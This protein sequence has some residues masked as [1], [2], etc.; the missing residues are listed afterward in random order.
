MRAH[1]DP[2][3]L[4]LPAKKNISASQ[5]WHNHSAIRR[6]FCMAAPPCL[7]RSREWHDRAKPNGANRI[8]AG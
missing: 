2:V 1:M 3:N 8:S 6:R 5:A 7:E 4:R